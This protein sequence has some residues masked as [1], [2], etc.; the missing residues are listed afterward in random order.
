MTIKNL[1]PILLPLLIIGWIIEHFLVITLLIVLIV[2]VQVAFRAWKAQQAKVDA[3]QQANEAEEAERVLS[4]SLTAAEPFSYASNAVDLPLDLTAG[5]R[6]LAVLPGTN[7]LEVMPLTKRRG[8]WGGP[9][10]RVA[11]GLSF[12]LG[13]SESTSESNQEIR[14]VDQGT[15][16]ITNE[17]LEFIGGHD[18]R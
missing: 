10:I 17:R 5:E 8:S 16:V 15:L 14:N 11:K 13:S 6:V 4:A 1:L 18:I 3:Q 9:T 2:A 12:R 7:L